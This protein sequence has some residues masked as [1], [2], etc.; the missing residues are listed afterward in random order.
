MTKTKC[1]KDADKAAKSS[2]RAFV[3]QCDENGAFKKTQCHNG[4]CWCVNKNGKELKGTRTE[5]GNPP[6]EQGKAD[7]GF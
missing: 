5:F 7:L 6:C 2:D 3:P 4:Q 1:Q